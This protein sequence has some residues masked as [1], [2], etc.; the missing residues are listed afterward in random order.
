MLIQPEATKK[1]DMDAFGSFFR[2]HYGRLLAYCQLFVKDQML[3][4]DLVQET[5]IHFWEKRSSLDSDRQMESLLFISLRNRCF[6]FLRD[7]NTTSKKL[8][9]YK[10]RTQTLQYI[11]QIDY[12][13]EEGATLEEQL[14]HELD[15]AVD[16]LPMR[17]RDVFRLAKLEGFK[18]REVAEKLG[19]SVKAVERQLSIAKSKIEAHMKRNHSFQLLFFLF[20]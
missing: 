8:K 20:F 1:G 17:C 9:E 11:S 3:A 10:E 4:E 12:L 15:A 19:I 14:I 2:S 16:Q 7:Q 13:N 6:N 18:N 5:F